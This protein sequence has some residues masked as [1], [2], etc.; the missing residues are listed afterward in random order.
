MR[1]IAGLISV[2]FFVSIASAQQLPQYTNYMLNQFGLNPAAVPM[3]SCLEVKGGYR[4]QWVGFEGAPETQFISAAMFIPNKRTGYKKGKHAVG[5][6]LE[7]DA[8]PPTKRNTVY[9]SYSF[10]RQITRELWAAVGVHAGIMQYAYD[11]A[12]IVIVDRPDPAIYGN[13]SSLI[14]PDLNPGIWI[15]S[16][17]TYGGLSIKN[18]MI[19]KMTKVFGYENRLRHH[20]Y[21]TYGHRF[22]S[23]G[24]T[25]SFIPSF[26]LKFAPM[27]P[28]AA[29]L[30]FMVDYRNKISLGLTYRNRD[31][32]CALIRFG[33][34]KV[35]SVGYSFDFT[36]SKLRYTSSNTHEIVLGI[37]FCKQK[38]FT[39]TPDICP[40]YR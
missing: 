34:G 40:A 36:T 6:Y 22:L 37:K 5:V 3:N 39:E 8:T 9:L 4:Q 2:V 11:M 13:T 20:Y 21:V 19:N 29:D 12:S 31:A 28:I 23:Y 32:L 27:S 38:E 16:K 10:H 17:N 18:A 35:I 15:Y 26:N 33:I 14:Y 25:F 7:G 1:K 24:K 30:N